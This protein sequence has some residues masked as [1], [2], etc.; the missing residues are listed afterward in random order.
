M[1]WGS[2]VQKLT[3]GPGGSGDGQLCMLVKQVESRKYQE[4]KTSAER[5][6]CPAIQEGRKTECRLHSPAGLPA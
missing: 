4:A 5:R 3:L 2:E 6:S 1:K